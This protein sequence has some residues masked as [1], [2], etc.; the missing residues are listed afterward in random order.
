MKKHS[1]NDLS[2]T[3]KFFILFLALVL[4][5]F[6][7]SVYTMIGLQE[8]KARSGTVNVAGLQRALSQNITKNA[9]IYIEYEG[10]KREE[11]K[12]QLTELTK[13]Y[14]YAL[15][16]LKNGNKEE[17]VEKIPKEA[18]EAVAQLENAW[19]PF[20]AKIEALINGDLEAVQYIVDHNMKLFNLADENT[21]MI[22]GASTSNILNII[23]F[24]F[25]GG[26][27]SVVICLVAY[28]AIRM[29]I[30]KPI[31][32]MTK[33]VSELEK[34]DLRVK[35]AVNSNDQIGILGQK[36]NG[37]RD[38]MLKILSNLNGT[39]NE[40]F[41]VSKNLNYL[42]QDV[43]SGSQEISASFEGIAEGSAHQAKSI[44]EVNERMGQLS[45]IIDKVTNSNE[46]IA[47]K[48]ENVHDVL[49]RSSRQIDELKKSSEVTQS[50]ILLI[51]SSITALTERIYEI[52]S[53]IDTIREISTQTN[54][55]ALNASIEAARA[56]E[57]G[58][59]FAVVAG[60]V[61]KL[62]EETSLATQDI[63]TKISSI[64]TEMGK[65]VKAVSETERVSKD[66]IISF[67]ET[68]QVFKNIEHA[69]QEMTNG[70]SQIS[71]NVEALYSKREEMLL[72]M[73]EISQVA[74]EV[75]ASSIEVTDAL[76]S[77]DASLGEVA[78]EAKDLELLATKNVENLSFFKVK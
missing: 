63:E 68:E 20:K 3:K 9:L 16:N 48:N 64:K 52:A 6:F 28:L 76:K 50:H 54:L 30:E 59:G 10:Q 61:R 56:G 1:L 42:Y 17:N 11:A 77:R 34:G 44:E 78:K 51:E 12:Q 39:S 33:Q 7:V 22:E 47:D 71:N 60:E 26:L 8:E 40:M 24:S 15:S 5:S 66:Q 23:V 46:L 25:L 74:E 18:E 70:I 36:V 57:V 55:L 13:K 45:E 67:Q 75:A 31:I 14:D 21:K 37:L 35:V 19:L 43:L 62:A 27:V 49:G 58:Q 2:L 65:T 29:K 38:S 69:A 72:S 32:L 4:M 53:I 73:Q 41:S